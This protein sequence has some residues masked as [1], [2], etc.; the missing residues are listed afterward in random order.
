MKTLTYTVTTIITLL[1][2]MIALSTSTTTDQT[3]SY[4]ESSGTLSVVIFGGSGDLAKKKTF[5]SLFALYRTQMIPSDVVLIGYGRRDI[6]LD[7]FRHQ[8]TERINA[9]GMED[10]LEEFKTRIFY[11]KGGY[12]AENC[13]KLATMLE[14]LESEVKS[15]EKHNRLFYLALPPS[16]FVSSAAAIKE[17]ALSKNGWNRIIVEKP[18]GV[19]T[20]SSKKLSE[21]LSIWPEEDIYRI[22]HYLGK[23][24]VQNIIPLRFSNT[25]FSKI[26]DRDHIESV[27][28]VFEENIGTAGRG[29]Y[30]DKSGIIRDVMQNHL[31]QILALVAM[32]EPAALEA[33]E[34]RNE[35][36]KVLEKIPPIL[37]KETI[38]GQYTAALDGSYPAY[39]D[40]DTVPDASKTATYC[41]LTAHIK[42][43]RWEGV[44]FVL[45]AAKGVNEK[46]VE[47]VIQFK[48]D[49]KLY[50]NSAGNQLVL[51]IQPDMKIA[52]KMNNKQPG[53]SEEITNVELNYLYDN[54]SSSTHIP[55]AYER[56]ILDAIQ[57]NTNS[58]VRADELDAAWKIFTPL[59]HEIE[60]TGA[61]PEM[62]AFGTEGVEQ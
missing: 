37:L 38:L 11:F 20:E 9:V 33:E 56:L 45:K 25:L 5:P 4:D 42:N 6:P 7:L 17:G 8:V 19:D 27:K 49:S 16:V 51:K 28:I 47:V 44:P 57:A 24:M 46:K 54:L 2:I 34:I 1:A 36:V 31:I 41:E 43:D 58:F 30:F 23:E 12:D 50:P 55:D 61:T 29:G 40:D 26:W 15:N 53:I 48:Q 52:Y 14:E 22:D 32:D 39:T 35:K 18:F 10:I 60:E 59:L 62:Y 3:V 21:G 13:K